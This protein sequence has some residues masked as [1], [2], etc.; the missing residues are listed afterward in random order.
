MPSP[1]LV[2][3]PDRPRHVPRNSKAP[4]MARPMLVSGQRK[5]NMK[6]QPSKRAV[7]LRVEWLNKAL[8]RPQEPF[9]GK[10]PNCKPTSAFY[11]DHG[12]GGY[13]LE[14]QGN[15]VFGHQ[16]MTKTELVNQ[17]EA[18]LVAIKLARGEHHGGAWPL[19]AKP[20]QPKTGEPCHCRPGI[21]RDNCPQCEGTGMRIDFAAIRAR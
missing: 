18:I 2:A 12:Y 3:L 14:T 7:D 8:G 10:A 11:V 4:L 20:Y 15:P 19:E 17:L 6:P 1:E 13:R 5:A 9:H 16:R 21:E